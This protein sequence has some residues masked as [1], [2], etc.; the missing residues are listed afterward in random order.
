MVHARTNLRGLDPSEDTPVHEP[1]SRF[2]G[3]Y[4]HAIRVATLHATRSDHFLPACTVH[5]SHSDRGVRF[6]SGSIKL[7]QDLLS[8]GCVFNTGHLSFTWWTSQNPY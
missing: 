5:H 1:G 3:R 2:D 4:T 8:P 7:S 6:G